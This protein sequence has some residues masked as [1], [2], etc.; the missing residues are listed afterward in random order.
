M[1]SLKFIINNNINCQQATYC[2]YQKKALRHQADHFD[3][4]LLFYM[5]SSLRFNIDLYLC[6]YFLFRF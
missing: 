2:V 6:T 3:I 5:L 1:I 4:R